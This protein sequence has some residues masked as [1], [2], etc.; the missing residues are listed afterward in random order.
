LRERAIE[1]LLSEKTLGA[2]ARRCGVNEK[3]LRRWRAED[4]EFKQAFAQARTARFHEAMDRVQA[5]TITAVAT[6]EALMGPTAPPTVRLGAARTVAE[7][8]MHQHEADTIVKRLDE[9]ERAARR[10]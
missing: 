4:E 2:A 5:L 9:L 3:T 7:L 1:A 8:G 10:G 6:L